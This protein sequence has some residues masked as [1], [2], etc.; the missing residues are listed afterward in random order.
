MLPVWETTPADFRRVLEV[1]LVGA[2]LRLRAV[3]DLMRTQPMQP[4][5]GHVVNVAS[6]QGKEGMRGRLQRV[7]GGTDRA[8]QDRRQGSGA[9]R[10]HG[11]LH[12]TGRG[13]S[14]RWR[15]R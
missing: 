4:L 15:T 10:H 12:Y 8:D 5:R 3:L 14:Q 13:L 6:I 11:Q 1:N 7:E 2:Y 9:A